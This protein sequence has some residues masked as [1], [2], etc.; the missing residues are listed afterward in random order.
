MICNEALEKFFVFYILWASYAFLQNY[1]ILHELHSSYPFKGHYYKTLDL[2]IWNRRKRRN[3]RWLLSL[4]PPRKV[5]AIILSKFW[6]QGKFCAGLPFPVFAKAV[7]HSP[8]SLRVY[9]PSTST[10][11]ISQLLNW[12]MEYLIDQS[13]IWL[14]A[15]VALECRPPG[16]PC[17]LHFWIS[18]HSHQTPL[19]ALQPLLGV[20]LVGCLLE[21]FGNLMGT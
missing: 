19:K 4:T 5:M 16:F 13:E 6:E 14:V 2:A 12:G 9:G 20:F 21:P 18:N 10:I 15:G 11:L 3:V 17:D 8:L 1:C 7:P